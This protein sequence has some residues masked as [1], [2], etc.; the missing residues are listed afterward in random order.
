ME[1]YIVEIVLSVVTA[2]V[3]AFCGFLGTQL[4]KYKSLLKSEQDNKTEEFF[5]K[6]IQP[7][8]DE[9]E[10]LRDYIRKTE[11][12]EEHHMK[13]IISSY[14][15]RLVQLCKIHLRK[16]YM[17]QDEY[18][19]LSEFYKLYTSLGG[20]GQAKEYFEKTCELSIKNA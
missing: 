12:T 9:I 8:I 18:D 1:Q 5:D 4:K 16:G 7:V 17:A 6:K 3:L 15:F 20:N 19:Q 13:L 10:E 14:K 11:K 2:G